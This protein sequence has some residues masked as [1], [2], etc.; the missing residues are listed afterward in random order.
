MNNP[1]I[2]DFES[3][4]ETSVWTLTI[5]EILMAIGVLFLSLIV[6]K[7][8]KSIIL[9]KLKKLSK[10]TKNDLDDVLMD[11][12]NSIKPYFYLFVSLYISLKYLSLPASFESIIN[13]FF[14]LLVAFQAAK[15]LEVLI[16]Y[17]AKKMVGK[18]G[19][20]VDRRDQRQR[21]IITLVLKIL[22]WTFI[23]LS[24][25]SNLGI[26]VTSLIAGLGISGVAIAFALQNILGDIFSS[27][28]IYFDKPFIEGDFIIIGNDMGTVKKIGIKST[29]IETLQGEELVVSNR[30][31]TTARVH[32][33]KKMDKRRIVFSFGVAYETSSEKLRKIPEMVKSIILKTDLAELDRVNFK[34][35]GD[36]SLNYEVVYYVSVPD[37][38]KYMDIQEKINL[39][40]KD[41]FEREQIEFAY[42]TYTIQ[43]EKQ[44]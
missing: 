23:L 35:F 10:I 21:Q 4:L 29:R 42:P 40:L 31:L 34:E 39:E 25:L 36:F 17:G 18:E 12:I 13:G 9:G 44:N 28:S 38:N 26:N 6:L 1:K 37:Y 19:E 14:V 15:S 11:M 20:E 16:V 30:E 7:I 32:N 27:F 5:K 3:F 2:I 22:L 24:A 43:M 33:Y 41:Q 8:F